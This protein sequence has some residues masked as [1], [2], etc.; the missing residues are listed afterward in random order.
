MKTDEQLTAELRAAAEGLL[1]M[2]ETD[3]PLEIVRWQGAQ[4]LTHDLLRRE[5]GKDADAPV[6]ETTAAHV[7]R[8][9]T[10]E[11][12]W[13]GEEEL[14]TARRFQSL[15]RLLE[16]NLA[17]LTAYRVGQ[18]DISIYLLGKTHEGNWLGLATRAVET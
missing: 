18:I 8:A 3:A 1:Y 13:K 15:A 16:E 11:P 10:S 9:A 6:E 12:E 4:T 14:R 5:A 7:F 17:G 2:S